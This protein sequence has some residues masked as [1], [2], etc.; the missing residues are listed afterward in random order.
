M[1][2]NL[3]KDISIGLKEELQS[4]CREHGMS[5]SGSKIEISDRI[6]TFLRTGEI[7]KPIRK[8]KLNSKSEIQA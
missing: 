7:K 1:R 6:E 5:A 3:T 4:F 8:S 2:P